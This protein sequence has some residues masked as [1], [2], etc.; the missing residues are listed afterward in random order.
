MR[1]R[2][3]AIE[4]KKAQAAAAEAEQNAPCRRCVWASWVGTGFFCPLPYCPFRVQ[5]E[6]EARKRARKK[7]K[8]C[9]KAPNGAFALFWR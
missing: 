8:R 6:K 1:A 7:V 4:R 2:K 3:C 9:V 5:I